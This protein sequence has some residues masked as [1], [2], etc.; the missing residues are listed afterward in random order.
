MELKRVIKENRRPHDHNRDYSGESIY[1]S[2]KALRE[3]ILQWSDGKLK[4]AL[5]MHC[6]VLSGRWH[7][8]IHFV[9]FNEKKPDNEQ[10]KYVNILYKRQKGELRMNPENFI[11]AYGTDWNV[12]S[13]WSNGN[14]FREWVSTV[15]GI[16]LA[17]SLELPYA[18]NEGQMVTPQN[19]RLFGKDLADTIQFYMQE[20]MK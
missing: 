12:P 15:E 13:T 11:L 16:S 19:A 20:S 2:T 8:N 3:R 6:P 10:Q 5:D 17:T 7:E 18:N 1:K 9:G 4:V 14:F